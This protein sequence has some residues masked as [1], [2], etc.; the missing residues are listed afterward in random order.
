VTQQAAVRVTLVVR[1]RVQGVGFRW[2]TQR[3]A[4]RLGLRGLVRNTPGGDVEI[5]AQGSRDACEKLLQ[6]VNGAHAPGAVRAVDAAWS[7]ATSES[8]LE[9]DFRIE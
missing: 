3:R 9:R 1:G 4:R 7:S 5:I 6:D 8:G 2:W